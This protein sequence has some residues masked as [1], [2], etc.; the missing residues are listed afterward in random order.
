M[1]KRPEASHR[2]TSVHSSRLLVGCGTALCVHCPECLPL[3]QATQRL[4]HKTG[5]S[6]RNIGLLRLIVRG[7][8]SPAYLAPRRPDHLH[9]FKDEVLSG[10]LPPDFVGLDNAKIPDCLFLEDSARTSGATFAAFS[11]LRSKPSVWSEIQAPK[12][13]CIFLGFK[14]KYI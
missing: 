9:F 8:D 13:T 10:H 5:I 1:R 3:P 4:T 6:S 12:S 7:V 2:L 11:P 14:S